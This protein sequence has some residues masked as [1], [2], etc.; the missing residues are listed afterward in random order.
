MRLNKRK[1]IIGI[2][3]LVIVMGAAPY[4]TGQLVKRQF[5]E[6]L[7]VFSDLESVDIKVL[8]Y[9]AGWVTSQAKTEV[10]FQ[11]K[12][13]PEWL[14][15]D[16][17]GSYAQLIFDHTIHHGPF[18]PGKPGWW[19]E[20]SF[21]LAMI[22]SSLHL[23]DAIK[24]M[25]SQQ[26]EGKQVLDL[27]SEIALDGSFFAIFEGKALTLKPSDTAD[28]ATPIVWKGI[29]GKF[30]INRAMDEMAGDL[31]MPGFDWMWEDERFIGQDFVCK[32]QKH[33][34][35]EGLWLGKDNVF[36]QQFQYI[37]PAPQQPLALSGMTIGT[38]LDENQSLLDGAMSVTIESISWG[39][40]T[41]GPMNTQISMSRL[42][43]QI[44]KLYNQF[45][46][47]T[48]TNQNSTTYLLGLYKLM[49]EFLKNK[50]EWHIDQFWLKTPEG[51]VKG[52]IQVTIGGQEADQLNQIDQIFNSLFVSAGLLMPQA[53][54]KDIM[55]PYYQATLPEKNWDSISQKV[56]E[57]ILHYVKTGILVSNNQEYI[58]DMRFENGELSLNG[59]PWV[60]EQEQ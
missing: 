45:A 48:E 7:A 5:E 14:R 8:D 24:N 43:P 41:V 6:V 52:H 27:Q 13:L 47:S 31:V 51:D 32:T 9:K 56:D 59:K 3:I 60:P 34:S 2:A 30:K 39:D 29:H 25:F 11:T 23:S 50:P 44:I 4:L 58:V 49:P 57:D 33:L 46:K 1:G 18:I 42:T 26:L 54:L 38:R 21:A 22:H 53:T 19:E 35:P 10:T 36:M 37:P 55:I 40:K 28:G 15:K 17:E 12:F 20:G 16:M